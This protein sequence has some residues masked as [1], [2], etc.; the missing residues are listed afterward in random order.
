MHPLRAVHMHRSETP[1][2]AIDLLVQGC[3]GV[4]SSATATGTS[5]R[6]SLARSVFG[7]RAS[8]K[9]PSGVLRRLGVGH[10]HPPALPARHRERLRRLHHLPVLGATVIVHRRLGG[11]VHRR[12]LPR[13]CLPGLDAVS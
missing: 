2:C 10:T 13:P 7:P 1:R 5:S 8:A 12:R 3:A 6:C 11:L 4:L 9:R